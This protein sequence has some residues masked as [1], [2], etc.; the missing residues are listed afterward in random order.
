MLMLAPIIYMLQVYDRVIGSGSMSTLAMLT[1]LLVCLLMA[2]GGF[3][4][5]RSRILISASNRIEKDL[6]ERVF[7]ATFQARP[8]EQAAKLMPRPTRIYPACASFLP[9]M[10]CSPSSTP[11]GSPSM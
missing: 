2:L 1:I 3:E 9:E 10:A 11:P 6:S 7:E 5:V 8:A 4:W